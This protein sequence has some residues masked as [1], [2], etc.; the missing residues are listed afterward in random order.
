MVRVCFAG[1]SHDQ[2]VQLRDMLKE[3]GIGKQGH[4]R[5][6][7]DNARALLHVHA[8]QQHGLSYDAAVKA[9]AQAE[10][11]SPSTLRSAAQQFAA[12]GALTPPPTPVDRSN[13]LH[14]FYSGE[15]GPSLAAQLLIHR[16]LHEVTLENTFESCN[17]L[18]TALAAELGVVVSKSTV[19]RW[20]HA[21]GYQYGKKHFVNH[22]RSYRNA[23]IRSYIYKYAAALKEQEDGSAIIVYMD[24]SY[25]HAH[26]CSQ[27]LW[28]SLA[29]ATKNEVRGDSKGKRIIIIHAMTKDGL[30]A[31][32]GVEPSNI[33]TELYHSCA[34]IFDE[35]CVDGVTPADYHD[36]INGDKFIG[37]M[38][39]RLFPTVQK[40]Y[41]GKKMYL[42]LDNAKYHHH[43]GPDWFS[44]SSKKKGQLADFL[45]QR[46]VSSI[47]VDDGRVVPASKFSADARGKAGGPTL[48]QLKAAAKAHIA[49]HP[50]INTTVPQQL[51]SDQGYELLY[52]PPYVSDLQ[53]IEMIWAF[54]KAL[55]A[56]QSHRA[57]TARACAVQTREA[58][59]LVTAELC[60]KQIKHCHAWIEQFMQSEQGGSL[61]Q[62]SSMQALMPLAAALQQC[63]DAA[64]STAPPAEEDEEEED[65]A[66]WMQ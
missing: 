17:T 9:T 29:T 10:L 55:V 30:L 38:R 47:T 36:T 37:W 56:R 35:V 53:P 21:L 27:Y 34:L 26:H 39:Q 28:H 32:E 59:D 46:N 8:H 44:P 22:A 24:E 11:A 5:S 41:P 54:T 43:R 18:R 15:S 2:L 64:F 12:T 20:L 65:E 19:R 57:R 31:V 7:T 52:T 62:F 48:V 63:D 49:S 45:R 4:S 66:G 13:P 25:I 60:Q 33:L 61:Q 16:Q 51:M 1:I 40:L 42:V 58:M 23:L 50:E 6:A 3:E 14:P